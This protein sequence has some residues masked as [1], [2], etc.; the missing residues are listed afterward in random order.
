MRLR[1]VC[2]VLIGRRGGVDGEG[3][4]ERRALQDPIFLKIV[5]EMMV[6]VYEV[7]VDVDRRVM[8]NGLENRK[9][10]A[11]M[12]AVFIAH[13]W[14]IFFWIFGYLGK[15]LDIL[16]IFFWMFGNAGSDFVDISAKGIRE[17]ARARAWRRAAGTKMGESGERERE[18]GGG[19]HSPR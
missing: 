10:R 16:W 5:R 3:G 13:N 8:G 19:V 15:F 11:R 2:H 6:Y 7:G 4:G 14:S 1:D 12:L 17:Q 9:Y 18:R